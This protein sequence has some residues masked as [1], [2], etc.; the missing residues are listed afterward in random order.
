MGEQDRTSDSIFRQ[1]AIRHQLVR[2]SPRAGNATVSRQP[3]EFKNDFL[4]TAWPMSE[5]HSFRGGTQAEWIRKANHDASPH[6]QQDSAAMFFAMDAEGNAGVFRCDAR[7][8]N[9]R[10]KVFPLAF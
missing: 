2:Y 10:D 9:V 1:I 8:C 3:D 5:G 6:Q 4:K 7:N